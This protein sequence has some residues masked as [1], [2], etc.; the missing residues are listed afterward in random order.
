MF[1]KEYKKPAL[2]AGFLVGSF[3]VENKEFVTTV[4][5]PTPS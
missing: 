5:L 3:T 2:G 4:Y 1:A